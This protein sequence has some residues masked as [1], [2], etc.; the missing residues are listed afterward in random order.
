MVN[1][2]SKSCANLGDNRTDDSKSFDIFKKTSALE[3]MVGKLRYENKKLVADASS[4]KYRYHS[5]IKIFNERTSNVHHR[6]NKLRNKLNRVTSRTLQSSPR[7]QFE[8][9]SPSPAVTNFDVPRSSISTI[10]NNVKKL[11]YTDKVV[12]NLESLFQNIC[13]IAG[14]CQAE[15]V[16]YDEHYLNLMLYTDRG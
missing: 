1:L 11:Q 14:F 6:M 15:L 10:F 5:S 3:K 8:V 4:Y 7:D 12:N 2:A 9:I 16:I 13:R